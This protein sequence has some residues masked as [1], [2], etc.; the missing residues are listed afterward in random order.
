VFKKGTVFVQKERPKRI[1]RKAYLKNKEKESP[2]AKDSSSDTD[3][4][5]NSNILELNCD[6]IG[7]QFWTDYP[8]ILD[9]L[10]EESIKSSQKCE[11]KK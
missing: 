8:H 4:P 6:I 9:P 10:P 11:A 2:S 7:D 1:P 5:T 3:Q